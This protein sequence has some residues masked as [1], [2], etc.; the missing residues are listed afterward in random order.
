MLDPEN[1]VLLFNWANRAKGTN[2]WATPGGGLDE[3]EG[4]KDA[5]RRELREEAG[6]VVDAVEG[7]LWR[8][9]HFFRSGAPVEGDRGAELVHQ[10]ESFFL[11][12]VGSD[13]VT[14]E[15]F[16]AFEADIS[17][18]HRWWSVEQL[19]ATTERVFPRGLGALLREVLAGGVPA[20]AVPI[21]G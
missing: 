21:K 16:D 2:W 20:K 6:I 9:D 14:T 7:P 13:D 8:S 10:F 1:R 15:G 19:E 17:L 5:A 11:A 12:R 4:S 18:G 3:G